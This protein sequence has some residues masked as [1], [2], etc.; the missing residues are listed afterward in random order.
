MDQ[1]TVTQDERLSRWNRVS[2]VLT[3]IAGE[4]S[5]AE[6]I[7]RE[8]AVGPRVP[9]RGSPH[10]LRV[11]EHRDADI[12]AGDAPGIVDPVRAL[13]QDALFSAGAVRVRHATQWR[14]QLLHDADGKRALFCV[15]YRERAARGTNRERAVDDPG[16]FVSLDAQ[17]T[18]RFQVLGHNA[19]IGLKVFNITDH[20]NPRDY[21]GNLASAEFGGFNNS[22]GRTF[23]GKWVF[24]F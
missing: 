18:K 14:M 20:F 5:E 13:A 6:R 16:A 19:T 3:T 23:R 11:V 2:P 7:R 9:V 24:E 21:Q 8:Q 12:F 15:A 17:I 10:V 1:D 4:L 22:V